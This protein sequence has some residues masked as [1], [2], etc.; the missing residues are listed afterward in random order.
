MNEIPFGPG[1]LAVIALY[2]L[3]LLGIGYLAYRARKENSLRDFYLGGQGFGFF[4]LLLTLFA[5]QYSG[6]T[7]LGFTGK[8]YR[9]GY[10]WMM[11]L[12]FMTAIVVCYLLFAPQLH[13][14]AKKHG[15]ITPTDFL[16]H[17]YQMPALDT[18]ASIVMIAA[19]GNFMLAQLMAM[20]R[21][22]EG[23][24]GS[25]SQESGDGAFIGGV[26]G[27]AIIIVIYESLGGMR[28][29]AWTDAIQGLILITGFLLLIGMMFYE[30]GSLG[31]ATKKILASED[32]TVVA[33]A[34]PPDGLKL[35]EWLSYILLVGIGG[36]LYPQAIQRIYAARDEKT[37][38]RSLGVMAFMPLVT[39]LVVVIVGVMG[40]VQLGTLDDSSA[41]DRVLPLL[42][43]DIALS[44]D[45]GYWLV[46]VLFAAI[47]AA[48][49]STADSALLSISSMVTKDLYGRF[50]RPDATQTHL[51]AVGKIVSCLLITFLVGL[52]IVLRMNTNLM[53]L[54]DIKFSLLIQLAPAF[55]VGIHLKWLRS[56]AVLAGLVLGLAVALG[57]TI[58]GCGK[59]EGIHAGVYGLGGNLLIVFLWL[60]KATLR[61]FAIFTRRCQ[62]SSAI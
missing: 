16:R 26:I 21:V 12:H 35:R 22:M 8:A 44:S 42:C 49:M 17:R 34:M 14:A 30:F 59:V 60:A 7:L 58:V 15:F 40:I 2:I 57:M 11:C 33:K 13:R 37:L 10:S 19:L 47:L 53:G 45:L 41:T 5:T 38:R 9:V 1:A 52:A 29:V 32:P 3:S 27:L 28:A 61:T 55:I 4:V 62:N 6:N 46:V 31:D 50:V 39:T 54:L 43:R 51:A 25:K 23:L 48:V 20:G 24:V 18:L 56:G 36:A